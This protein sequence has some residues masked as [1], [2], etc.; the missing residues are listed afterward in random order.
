[1][2]EAWDREHI[3]QIGCVKGEVVRSEGVRCNA[4]NVVVIL[5]LCVQDERG[6]DGGVNVCCF[7]FFHSEYTH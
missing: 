2:G 4:E 1:M 5:C 7:H 3:L 6:E